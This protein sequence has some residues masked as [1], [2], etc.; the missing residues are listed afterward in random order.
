MAI[1]KIGEWPE[2]WTFFPII[3]L[4]KK[5]AFKQCANYI[6]KIFLSRMQA[7]SFFVSYWRGYE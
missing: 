4:P 3:P 5:E 1:L 2:E 6:K 7:K